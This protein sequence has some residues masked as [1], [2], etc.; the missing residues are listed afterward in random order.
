MTLIEFQEKHK[1]TKSD[2]ER[3]GRIC[4]TFNGKIIS[5]TER[6]ATQWP[7]INKKKSGKL[8]RTHHLI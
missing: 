7:Q 1:F 8:Q 3:L 6:E 5:I 4:K 2:M